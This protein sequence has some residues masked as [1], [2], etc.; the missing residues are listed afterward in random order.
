MNV[1]TCLENHFK[2]FFPKSTSP[3]T[4]SDIIF[5]GT[6][7]AQETSG[8]VESRPDNS[9]MNNASAQQSSSSSSSSSSNP[10]NSSAF[11]D[12]EQKQLQIELDRKRFLAEKE[13]WESE[14]KR[15][16]AKL[17]DTEN[18]D[19]SQ[20]L[21][22]AET[23]TKLSSGIKTKRSPSLSAVTSTTKKAKV[24]PQNEGLKTRQQIQNQIHKLQLE[25][26]S[27]TPS[28]ELYVIVSKNN[29]VK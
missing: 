28:D 16:Q 15:A 9:V 2:I 24:T 4:N 18:D 1:F 14:K 29:S 11:A 12:L 23:P 8:I 5:T 10:G 22:I 3:D 25:L 7:S 6:K 20:P 13:R 19:S 17:S 26:P 21:T 27:E